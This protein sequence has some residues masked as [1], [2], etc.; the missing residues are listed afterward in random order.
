[1][2]CV[3]GKSR[4]RSCWWIGV[5]CRLLGANTGDGPGANVCRIVVFRLDICCQKAKGERL[6]VR[7]TC[8]LLVIRFSSRCKEAK[9]NVNKPAVSHNVKL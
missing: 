5:K 2:D 6:R 8:D 3:E 4:V 9:V 7:E 1:M